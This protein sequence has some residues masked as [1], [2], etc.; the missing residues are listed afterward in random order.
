MGFM[1]MGTS[2]TVTISGGVNVTDERSNAEG[3]S[4]SGNATDRTDTYTV[5][6]NKYWILKLARWYRANSQNVSVNIEIDG[7]Q[8]PIRTDINCTAGDMQ[9]QNIKLKAEDA[10]IVYFSTG[11]NG[12]LKSS[13]IYEEYDE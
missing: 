5:P 7:T 11:T 8:Y 3:Q 9:L 2:A 6:A 1:V 10:I 4:T 13:V 12:S